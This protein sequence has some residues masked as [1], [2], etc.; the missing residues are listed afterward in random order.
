MTV[1]LSPL[2]RPK[3]TG[4]TARARHHALSS[5]LLLD[6][7]GL[8]LVAAELRPVASGTGGLG[9]TDLIEL[10][11]ILIDIH[12]DAAVCRNGRAG[13][14][15]AGEIEFADDL[16]VGRRH[17]EQFATIQ[18]TDIQVAQLVDGRYAAVSG[19]SAGQ[20]HF[21][22]FVAILLVE[23][24]NAVSAHIIGVSLV[25]QHAAVAVAGDGGRDSL[26]PDGFRE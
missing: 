8:L 18:I 12:I 1:P 21:P 11:A 5:P 17:F 22:G 2:Y 25:I 19:S 7:A 13:T 9:A 15:F 16:S 14:G 26:F 6:R 4:E 23:A 3:E 20:R 24:E 10:G